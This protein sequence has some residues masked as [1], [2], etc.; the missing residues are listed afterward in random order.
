MDCCFF[1]L[2]EVERGKTVITYDPD[3]LGRRRPAKEW[4]SLMGKTK[5][6][7]APEAS[8]VAAAF[9]AEVDRRWRR[10]KAKHEHPEL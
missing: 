3:A 4:F 6:L 10:L 5:H 8:A 2:Y 1:P 9:E 7:L